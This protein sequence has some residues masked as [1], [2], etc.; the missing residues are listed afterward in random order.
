MNTTNM[1][2]LY[3]ACNEKENAYILICADNKEDAA[4]IAEE[5]RESTKRSG[6][7]RVYDNYT[8]EVSFCCDHVLTK[9]TSKTKCFCLLYTVD[10]TA[11]MVYAKTEKEAFIKVSNRNFDSLNENNRDDALRR[12]NYII[13]EFTPETNSNGIL[14]F[15]DVNNIMKCFR[16]LYTVDNT[17]YMVYAKTEEEAFIKVSDRNYDSLNEDNRDDALRRENY[18][19]DEFTPETN[20]D[21]IL[22]FIDVNNTMERNGCEA[23][24]VHEEK[25]VLI[26][27][28]QDTTEKGCGW[29][30]DVINSE[31]KAKNLSICWTR[32]QAR[33]AAEAFAK[34]MGDIPVEFF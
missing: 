21:G 34:T 16:L 6:K 33:A 28:C 25:N 12:E 15:Y 32:T 31:G 13:D 3:V 1:L 29:Y 24:V 4:M 5:F 19:I 14:E 10:N 17:A 8:G 2:N 27:V 18:I 7:F 23:G 20:G 11:Y 22:E 9:K 30:I 26:S